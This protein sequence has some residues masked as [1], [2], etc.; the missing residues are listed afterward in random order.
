MIV[1][2]YVGAKARMIRVFLRCLCSPHS[3]LN[4]QSRERVIK[5]YFIRLNPCIV[6]DDTQYYFTNSYKCF[7][8]KKIQQIDK[9]QNKSN[10]VVKKRC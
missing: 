7:W 5:Y 9:W 4:I 1:N 8:G 6:L 10:A 3:Q 2:S